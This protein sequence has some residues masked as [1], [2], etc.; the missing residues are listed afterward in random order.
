[1]QPRIAGLNDQAYTIYTRICIPEAG[2]I[3]RCA[4]KRCERLSISMVFCK[5]PKSR[6]IDRS[7]EGIKRISGCAAQTSRHPNSN[8]KSGSLSSEIHSRSIRDEINPAFTAEEAPAKGTKRH[9][10]SDARTGSAVNR[11]QG[12]S[13]IRESTISRLTRRPIVLWSTPGISPSIP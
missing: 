4:S 9:G 2:S 8:R 12:D 13:T 6:R 3:R 7:A 11:M 1:M 10:N 5:R